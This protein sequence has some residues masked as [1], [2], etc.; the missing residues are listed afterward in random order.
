MAKSN[1]SVLFA[2]QNDFLSLYLI[3]IGQWGVKKSKCDLYQRGTQR[4]RLKR[5]PEKGV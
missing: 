4:V 3:L 5:V 1:L 2:F